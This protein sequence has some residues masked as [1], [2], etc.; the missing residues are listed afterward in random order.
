M[1]LPHTS[2]DLAGLRAARW[3]RES[4]SGQF[5]KGGPDAQREQQ[6]RAIAS[7][8]LVDTGLAWQIAGSGAVVDRTPEWAEMLTAAGAAYDVL[9]V[10]Y[11]SRFARNVEVFART[12]RQLHEAGASVYFCDERLWSADE[13]HWDWWM[14]EAVEAE[15]YRRRLARRIREGYAA[16]FR[17]G[18]QGGSPGLGFRRTPPPESRLVI[19]PVGMRRAVALFERYATGS[20]SLA[21]LAAEDG[22]LGVEGIRAILTNPLY[23]GWAVRHRDRPDEVRTAAP[24]RADPPVDDEL[25]A[26]VQAVRAERYR[27]GGG[28]ARH[29]HLLAKRLWCQCG[30]RLRADVAHQRRSAPIRRYRHDEPCAA[31]SQRTVPARRLEAIVDAQLRGLRLDA[32]WLAR[33]RALAGREVPVPAIGEL[34]RRQ[35]ERELEGK[36]RLLARRQLTTAAFVAE[37]ERI[38]AEIAALERRPPQLAH[39]DPEL[40][41]N[42]LRTVRRTWRDADPEARQ[43]VVRAVFDR[44]V[45]VGDRIV[46]ER[47]TPWALAHGLATALPTTVALASPAGADLTRAI[48]IIGRAEELAAARRARSA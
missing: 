6:D 41:L 44:V 29:V 17:A 42:A 15:S 38:Q 7:H 27:G 24:W 8:G 31:W 23:N 35:L 40:A 37:T 48:Q 12:V 19:D 32:E 5:D 16:K 26:R 11:V 30:R 3:V 46:E 33:L 20:I 13:T 14:R 2:D 18:D 45:V 47:L 28:P 4:T 10:G 1:T 21:E 34:R 25:W 22:E 9:L 36:A 43:R 39:V